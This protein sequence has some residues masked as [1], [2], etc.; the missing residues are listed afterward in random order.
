MIITFLLIIYLYIFPFFFFFFFQPSFDSQNE[1]NTVQIV[2]YKN[3]QNWLVAI[4]YK[5]T[6]YK[7]FFLLWFYITMLCDWL[8]KLAPISQPIRCKTK[9]NCASLAHVFP[10]L[11]P[12]TC[13]CFEF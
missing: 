12:V 10:R 1:Y 4:V 2:F 3:C 13:N 9:T 7:N 6:D 5:S 11:A 8:I